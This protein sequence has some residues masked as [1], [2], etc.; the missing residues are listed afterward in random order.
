M[1]SELGSLYLKDNA[2]YSIREIARILAIEDYPKCL[3]IKASG[4]IVCY[5][6]VPLDFLE[7]LTE[8]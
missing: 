4:G 6:S 5:I 7:V 8:N 3:V 1:Q 2:L